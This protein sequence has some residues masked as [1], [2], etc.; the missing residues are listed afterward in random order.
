MANWTNGPWHIEQGEEDI[1][2]NQFYI[3][4]KGTE[5]DQTTIA[6]SGDRTK[7]ISENKSTAA[8]ISAAPDMA[9]ALEEILAI[10]ENTDGIAGHHMNGEIADWEEFEFMDMIRKALSKAKVE[11]E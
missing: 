8:L 10:A 6:I 3:C 5:C 11:T 9:E 7:L 2:D 4:H 1:D